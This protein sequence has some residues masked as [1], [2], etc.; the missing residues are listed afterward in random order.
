MSNIFLLGSIIKKIELI[1]TKKC[2]RENNKHNLVY[3][4]IY[5]DP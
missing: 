2:I 4:T 1:K 5:S 3:S